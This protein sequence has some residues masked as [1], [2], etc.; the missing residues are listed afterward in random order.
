MNS[1][2]HSAR[3]LEARTQR[4]RSRANA[5]SLFS[6]RSGVF[7]SHSCVLLMVRGLDIGYRQDIEE[8]EG[9]RSLILTDSASFFLAPLQAGRSVDS[10]QAKKT[11]RNNHQ[12]Q[13]SSRL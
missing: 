9:P 4:I 12:I 10:K 3:H 11:R 13:R 1:P 8:E 6:D 2:T 7:R 5:P